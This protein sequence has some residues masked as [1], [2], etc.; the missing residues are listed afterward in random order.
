RLHWVLFYVGSY[1]REAFGI[2][3]AVI[4]AFVL[5]ETLAFCADDFICFPACVAFEW[6]Q[7]FC[8]DDIWGYEQVD[9]IGHYYPGVQGVAMEPAVSFF[10][11]FCNYLCDF[12]SLQVKWAC[13]RSVQ[14]LV[15]CCE[16]FSRCQ[17]LFSWEWAV[18]RQ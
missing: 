7:P 17:D 15:H 10:D 13:G 8:C 2:S 1:S 4:V 11:R 12:W 16:G 6:S 14:Y 5:P 9:V 3:Y 18:G